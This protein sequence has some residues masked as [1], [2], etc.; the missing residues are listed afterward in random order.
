MRGKEQKRV[1]E[2]QRLSVGSAPGALL[3]M[4]EYEQTRDKRRLYGPVV[5][6]GD[7]KSVV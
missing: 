2:K 6:L 7:R 3:Q 4:H 5:T 1:S